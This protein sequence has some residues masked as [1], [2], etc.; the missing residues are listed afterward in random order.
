MRKIM[1]A[2]FIGMAGGYI[3]AFIG[4]FFWFEEL[5]PKSIVSLIIYGFIIGLI[6]AGITYRKE[7]KLCKFNKRNFP[8]LGSFQPNLYNIGK[9]QQEIMEESCEKD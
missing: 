7:N 4:N 3:G 2:L 5:F 8:L 6:C 9:T 1:T